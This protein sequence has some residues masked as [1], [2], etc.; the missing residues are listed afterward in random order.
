MRVNIIGGG[1]AG[2]A[3][4]YVLKRE[5]A[6]PVIYEAADHIA[7][8]ASGNDVGLYNPRFT[9]EFDAVGQFYSRAFYAALAV[10]EGFGD[11]IEWN[12]CGALHLMNDEKKQRR[13]PKTVKN[14]GWGEEGMRIVSAQDASEISAVQI[15]YDCLYL[16]QSGTVSPKKLCAHYAKGVEVYLNSSI[17][18]LNTLDG[19]ITVLANGVR[20]LSFNEASHLP[21]KAVR[22]QVT[23][24]KQS[25]KTA[26]LKTT[27]GYGGYMAPS[28]NGA[29][30]VGSTFQRW[31]DHSDLIEEDNQDNIE[32]MV[33]NL[34]E[35]T[36]AYD[37][38]GARAG[39]RTTS[40]DHFPVV[41]ALDESLYIS[42]AHGSHGILSSLLSAVILA[43]KMILKERDIPSSIESALS[44]DRYS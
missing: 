43:N 26:A 24:I 36:G 31:L 7:S 20:C 19:D 38:C 23:Y 42:T 2:C 33:K 44:P 25:D 22:G 34:P 15:P 40:K 3:L 13:F 32:K 35:L 39:V 29:H 27:I 8:G 12:P 14:W 4:A 37:V 16:P 21:L 18:D 10:F 17:A 41:G 30:C 11:A 28:I 1:L 5:G 9:A 6:E